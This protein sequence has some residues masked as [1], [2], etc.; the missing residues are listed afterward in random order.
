MPFCWR[1]WRSSSLLPAPA[2][3]DP[4][5]AADLVQESLLKAIKSGGELRDA[6]SSRAW[7]YRILRHAIIDLYRRRDVERKALEKL[8]QD[9]PDIAETNAVCRCLDRLI[10]TLKPEYATV[11]RA[12]DL[13]EQPIDRAARQLGISVNNAN[14]RLYRARRQLREKLETTCR[15]CAS[16]GCLDCTCEPAEEKSV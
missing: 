9:E 11:I 5:L 8:E 14:V 15:V 4:E 10:P 3:G 1:T 13:Q 12:V 2:S 6:E 16:H 7:F